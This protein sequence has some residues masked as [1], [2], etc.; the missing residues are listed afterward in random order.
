M[1]KLTGKQRSFLRAE[2][3]NLDPVVHVGKDGINESVINQIDEALEDHELLKVRILEST[4]KT[5]KSC[6]DEL[7]AAASA[8]VVQVIGGIAVL[9]RQN[10]EDSSY[11]LP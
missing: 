8:S 9:F 7:A 5:T 1:K 3:N 10:D 6:A 2:A 11:Q 4:G